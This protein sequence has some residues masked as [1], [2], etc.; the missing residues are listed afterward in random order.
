MAAVAGTC[1]AE[2]VSGRA[3]YSD[4]EKKAAV[5]LV[6]QSG[7]TATD[8]G[9]ELGINPD[10]LASWVR[11]DETLR[12]RQ[13]W[14]GRVRPHFDFLLGS[15]FTLTDVTAQGWWSLTVTYRSAAAGVEVSRSVEYNRVDM[16]LLRLVEGELPEY[17]V[18]V[19]DS[20]P[21]NTFHGDWL[22]RLRGKSS[23]Q[24]KFGLA[25]S[26]ID[27]QLVF[28][29]DALRELAPEFL[30]G[31]LTVLDQLEQLVREHA[32][33]S[34]QRV[35]VWTPSDAEPGSVARMIEQVKEITPIEVSVEPRQYE[36]PKRK[37][38][39]QG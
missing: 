28:W 12:S 26:E 31:D 37:R 36:R 39:S 7:R 2:F 21:L 30:D 3:R 8:V 33:Q 15:G 29:A 19:V 9:Q 11:A 18:F 16:S 5:E 10:T 6:R 27:D 23:N 38:P 20:V 4:E 17:P 14:V 25:D 1:H 34:P 22:L 32:A 13:E 24:P 35:T